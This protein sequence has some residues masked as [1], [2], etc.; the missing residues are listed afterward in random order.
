M[1]EFFFF[2]NLREQSAITTN[3]QQNMLFVSAFKKK[4]ISAF[5]DLTSTS[6]EHLSF[7]CGSLTDEISQAVLHFCELYL[8]PVKMHSKAFFFFI[9]AISHLINKSV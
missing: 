1:L 6:P 7:I 3:L 8:E 5:P 2:F 4:H 9:Y